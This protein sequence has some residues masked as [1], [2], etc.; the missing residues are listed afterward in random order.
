M[1]AVFPQQLL[2]RVYSKNAGGASP[3]SRNTRLFSRLWRNLNLE[4]DNR[5]YEPN[6]A[7]YI[8]SGFVERTSMLETPKR[9]A[10]SRR[11]RVV[12]LRAR[13]SRSCKTHFFFSAILR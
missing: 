7:G 13:L 4:G 9:A 5:C 11:P 10:S 12:R 6:I 1:V 3:T 8:S 2:G